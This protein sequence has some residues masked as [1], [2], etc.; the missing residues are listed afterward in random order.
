MKS[1]VWV[2]FAF[3]GA[4]FYQLSD[5]ADYAPRDGSLQAE[6]AKAR[7]ARDVIAAAPRPAT[8]VRPKAIAEALPETLPMTLPEA[9]VA[10]ASLTTLQA[11][12]P[13]RP[14]LVEPD[15]AANALA[16]QIEGYSLERL[17]V[18]PPSAMSAPDMAPNVAA[19]VAPLIT[20]AGLA[21]ATATE[22]TAGQDIRTVLRS[23]VNLRDGPGTQFDIV[24][25][26][27]SGEAVA[28][29]ENDGT[30][31]VRLRVLETGRV[32][33]MADYLISAAN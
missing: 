7:L 29:L 30:G 28:L 21:P 4:A 18:A 8:A 6:A 5:G 1:Y 13:A 14:A 10:R 32:G 33:W 15:R 31:W 12:A 16:R 2:T 9:V 27:D 26:L 25:K 22:G 3:L 17:A 20:P 19:L 11:P 24:T 23:R